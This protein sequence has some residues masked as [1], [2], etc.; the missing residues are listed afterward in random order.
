MFSS[1]TIAVVSIGSLCDLRK[2][3]RKKVEMFD[4]AKKD[5]RGYIKKAYLFNFFQEKV[6]FF[7]SFPDFLSYNMLSSFYFT[8][9]L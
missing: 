2:E 6:T 1:C 9:P 7:F 5:R 8:K 4:L 3:A